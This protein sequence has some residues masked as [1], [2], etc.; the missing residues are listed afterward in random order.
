MATASLVDFLAGA[1]PVVAGAFF[2]VFA[3]VLSAGTVLFA[4]AFL[5]VAIFL[6]AAFAAV[7]VFLAGAFAAVAIFLAGAFVVAAVFLAAADGIGA[8]TFF[9]TALAVFAFGASDD[10]SASASPSS[11]RSLSR[12]CATSV[13]TTTY[14]FI[15][16]PGIGSKTR[17]PSATNAS[18]RASGRCTMIPS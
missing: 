1:L 4:G 10:A 16:C 6:A 3:G 5:A 13:G 11:A 17:A 9:F 15:A 12:S 14:F 7:A 18:W 2:F 8:M